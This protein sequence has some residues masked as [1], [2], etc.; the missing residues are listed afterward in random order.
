MRWALQIAVP[1]TGFGPLHRRQL[2]LGFIVVE[3]GIDN[4]C[5]CATIWTCGKEGDE[6]P[7]L[8]HWSRH[9]HVWYGERRRKSGVLMILAYFIPCCDA[10]RPSTCTLV[11]IC[12]TE[13]RRP[14]GIS[15]A[16]YI[17]PAAC[18]VSGGVCGLA[19]PDN[20]H[21]CLLCPQNMSR[22]LRVL[23]IDRLCWCV[24]G[25]GRLRC[26]KCRLVCSECACIC[27]C[28]LSSAEPCSSLKRFTTG[29]S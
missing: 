5:V 19:R 4:G 23:K 28:V 20:R 9:F 7:S 17:S 13:D 27:L 22:V 25:E 12:R 24:A 15:Q 26:F 10:G 21:A 8:L 29:R 16:V 18:A 14:R 11:F 3:S 6:V 2:S 1:Y